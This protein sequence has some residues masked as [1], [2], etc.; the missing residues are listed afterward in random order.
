[1]APLLDLHVW[2]ES[3]RLLSKLRDYYLDDVSV[4]ND[5]PAV[6]PTTALLCAVVF[7]VVYVAPF[8]LSPTLRSTPI[9]SRDSP[10]VIRARVRAVG[11]TCIVCTVVTVYVLAVEGHAGPRDV[12]RLLA[13]WPTDPLDIAKTLALV[14]VLFVGPLY[15]SIIVNDDWREWSFSALKEGLFDSWTGYRNL[16]VAP[17]SEEYVFRSLTI[18][19]HLL[20]KVSP[21]RIVFLTPLIFGLAHLHHLVEFLQSRTPEGRRLPSGSVWISGIVRSLFQFTY[22]SLFGFFAAFVLLRTGNLWAAIVAHTFCNWM[23]LPRLWGRVGQFAS[24]YD[25]H[26]TPDVA[27]GKRDE[28]PGSP[29]KVANSSTQR[30]DDYEDKAAQMM[31]HGP[32]NLGVEWTVAYYALIVAGSYGFYLLLWPLT[33]S[34]NALA[35]F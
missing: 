2:G 4:A 28:D 1:M 21:T 25:V 9:Q 7:T 5:V 11:L 15:E 24:H 32:K 27:Q 3:S 26:I 14:A 8:Y 29:V 18:S 12:L 16:I 33:E 31:Q 34:R 10:T 13:V 30:Q 23:G 20:A 6:S 17:A 19:T 22:T 35:A